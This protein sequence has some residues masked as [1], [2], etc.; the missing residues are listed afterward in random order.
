MKAKG[1][2]AHPDECIPQMD[3][4]CYDGGRSDY[5]NRQLRSG[6]PSDIQDCAVVAVSV[7]LTYYPRV[8]S[9]PALSYSAT[10]TE[11]SIM[12]RRKMP[13][14][15]KGSRET[16]KEFFV[17]RFK[18]IWAERGNKG[19][20]KHQDP[21]YGV[22]TVVLSRVLQSKNFSFEFGKRSDERPLCLCSSNGTYIVDGVLANGN[23]HSFA[24]IKGVIVADY[25]F[26]K[27]YNGFHVLNIWQRH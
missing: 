25:D 5:F 7:A 20:A 24:L 13:W 4:D 21:K 23:G 3:F 16:W 11:L 9:S 19:T 6:V 17:R 8:S 1:I 22:N 18:E 14:K 12:N 2:H 26:R 10:L 15:R 27:V